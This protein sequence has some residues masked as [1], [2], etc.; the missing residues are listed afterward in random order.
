M[1]ARVGHEQRTVGVDGD[2][3]G[4]VEARL[5]AASVAEARLAAAGDC[6]DAPVFDCSDAVVVSVGDE[7]RAVFV[8]C[9]TDWAVEARLTCFAVSKAALAGS[10]GGIDDPIGFQINPNDCMRARVGDD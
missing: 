6:A 5:I 9:N 7:D 1:V 4:R 10:A 8:D 3:A 2:A